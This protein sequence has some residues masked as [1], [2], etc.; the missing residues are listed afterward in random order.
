M[1]RL[2]AVTEQIMSGRFGKDSLI[3]LATAENNI[4]YVRTVNSFYENAAFYV[5]TYGLSGK[6][7]QIEKNPVVAISGD[8]FTAHGNGVNLGWF[9]KEENAEIAEKMKVVFAEWID[10]GHNNFEDVNT[11]IL[12]IELTEGVLFS[13]GTRYAID[14]T[15]E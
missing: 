1:E 13:H 15:K 7:K 3:S 12:K 10:N 2:S 9:G 4:P 5:L 8:W 14:F 6:M 11:C